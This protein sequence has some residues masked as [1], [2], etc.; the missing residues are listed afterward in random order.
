MNDLEI[1]DNKT[2]KVLFTMVPGDYDSTY[3]LTDHLGM[4]YNVSVYQVPAVGRTVRRQGSY[5]SQ[6]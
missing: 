4:Q 5:K 6:E 2:G 3:L 1:V